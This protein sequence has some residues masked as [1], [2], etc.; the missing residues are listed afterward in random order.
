MHK[1]EKVKTTEQI[2]DEDI[3]MPPYKSRRVSDYCT[4]CKS[5]TTQEL[6]REIEKVADE[7]MAISQ[8]ALGRNPYCVGIFIPLDK[9][10]QFK[11]DKGAK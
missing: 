10:Q 8:I 1:T 5:Q 6:I 4:Q 3:R 7:P 11:K 9:W 2:N